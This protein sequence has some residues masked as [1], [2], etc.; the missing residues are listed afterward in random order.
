MRVPRL[1][2]PP[3][4]RQLGLVCAVGKSFS[5]QNRQRKDHVVLQRKPA[6]A[7][8]CIVAGCG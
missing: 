5:S 1:T 2:A 4:K 7:R 6:R 8:E 3:I